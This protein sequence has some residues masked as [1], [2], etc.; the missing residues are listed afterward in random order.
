MYQ[1]IYKTL[2]FFAEHVEC[3]ELNKTQIGRAK[4]ALEAFSDVHIQTLDSYCGGIVRQCANRYGIKPDFV[5]GS[6]D[7]E[8]QVKDMAFRYIL[9]NAENSAVQAFSEPGKIQD[10]AENVFAKIILKHTSLATEAGWFSDRLKNQVKEIPIKVG[11]CV[12]LTQDESLQLYKL[13]YKILEK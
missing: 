10:F 13:L 11:K 8:R 3:T 12:N 7:G 4:A 2:R 1:R 5:T 9:Q 6:S